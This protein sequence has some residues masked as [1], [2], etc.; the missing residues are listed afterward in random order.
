MRRIRTAVIALAGAAV[1]SV[2]AC[3]S[4]A[5]T[6]SNSS[7]GGGTSSA[8]SGSGASSAPSGGVIDIGGQAPLTGAAA[9]IGVDWQKSMELGVDEVNANG[10]V[11]VD[12]KKYTFNLEF[13]DNKTDPTTAISIAQQYLSQGVKF[14]VGPSVT[15]L[16]QTV[17]PSLKGGNVMVISAS[18]L[19]PGLVGTPGAQYL[20]GTQLPTDGASGTIAANVSAVIARWHP[21][22]V[23]ILEP[24]DP[25]GDDHV[26]A[27]TAAFTK[28]GVKIVYK[29]QFADTTQDFSSYI[30]KMQQAKPDAV[31]F[32]YF[33]SVATTFL[34]QAKQ[35]NFNP[36]FVFAP[37]VTGAVLAGSAGTGVDASI[38]I[39]TRAVDNLS[40]T[41]LNAFRAAYSAKFGGTVGPSDFY[42]LTYYDAIR[43][44]ARAM[45]IADSTSDLATISKAMS[46]PGVT[47]YPVRAESL[48]YNSDN[49]PSFPMQTEFIE[50]GTR[51]YVDTP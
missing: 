41:T 33:D 28:A 7:S 29:E 48:T 49:E 5:S 39:P 12:G 14:F 8:S 1:L 40:D 38:S 15:T 37:G 3:S 23:A 45:T 19:V 22:T 27:Y 31:V 47:N 13:Q 35:A 34:S 26:S 17:W 11:V 36:K 51:T 9:S 21:K 42:L 25:A 20:F 46:S 16:F 43:M 50:N 10:G 44:L 24:N 4:S 2:A 32:G 18:T 30:A 6:S